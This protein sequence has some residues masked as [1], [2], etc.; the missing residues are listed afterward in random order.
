[1]TFIKNVQRQ[2]IFDTHFVAPSLDLQCAA[3]I[4]SSTDRGNMVCVEE[5]WWDSTREQENWT[6]FK[7]IFGG[8][9]SCINA[10]NPLQ[11]FPCMLLNP[12]SP[13]TTNKIGNLTRDG[14]CLTWLN[15]HRGSLGEL[16][17]VHTCWKT[18]VT[19]EWG[20]TAPYYPWIKTLV[21][22]ITPDYR[23]THRKQLQPTA[24]EKQRTW[25]MVLK[26]NWR[27]LVFTTLLRN[28]MAQ[29][30]EHCL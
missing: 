2:N 7:V 25:L 26:I 19:P 24:A 29:T 15:S 30:L 10:P 12:C 13:V 4:T 20:I 1:M 18:R 27:E 3:A 9:L 6:C 11:S 8:C 21:L 5:N 22:F 23:D 17:T 16:F 14:Q 28:S